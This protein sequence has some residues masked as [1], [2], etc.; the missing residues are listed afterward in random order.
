MIHSQD[1][2]R[3]PI[4]LSLIEDPIVLCATGQVYCYKTMKDWFST[5]NRLCPRTNQTITDAQICRLPWLKQRINEW[6]MQHGLPPPAD[7]NYQAEALQG[8]LA[9]KPSS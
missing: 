8:A 7:N 9:G 3:D 2:F 5:G 4:S 1:E 6:R